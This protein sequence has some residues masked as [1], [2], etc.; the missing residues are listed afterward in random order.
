[1][2]FRLQILVAE[3][4]VVNLVLEIRDSL[5]ESL[6]TCLEQSGRFLSSTAF[7]QRSLRLPCHRA[8]LLLMVHPQLVGRRQLCILA[9]VEHC[10]LLLMPDP[11]GLQ[12]LLELLVLR[13]QWLLAR[14]ALFRCG[15]QFIALRHRLLMLDAQRGEFLLELLDVRLG[16]PFLIFEVLGSLTFDSQLLTVAHVR[17]VTFR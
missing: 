6:H 3:S 17:S 5:R 13:A 15:L 14:V 1:M 16:N 10:Q 9:F 12:F 4:D 2:E 7:L 8:C 11:Q